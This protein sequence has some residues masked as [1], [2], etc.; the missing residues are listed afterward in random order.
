MIIIIFLFFWTKPVV[1]SQGTIKVW[2]RNNI[3]L[4]E[5]AGD[6]GSKIPVSFD[7]FPKYLIEAVVSTEDST[8][9]KTP[10]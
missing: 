6:V 4:Y 1:K 5:S 10:G 3:L 8:F 2:D 9:W 7:K